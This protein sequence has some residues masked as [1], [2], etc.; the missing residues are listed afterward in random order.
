MRQFQVDGFAVVAGVCVSS[1]SSSWY[2]DA[3]GS[4]EAAGGIGIE[5]GFAFAVAG[6]KG[7]LFADINHEGAAR[8]ADRSKSLASNPRYK[9]LSA[10]L[11]VT[12]PNSVRAMADLAASEFGRIDYF[13]NAVGVGMK[14]FVPF[15]HTRDEDYDRLLAV[16]AKGAF[17]LSKAVIS[18]MQMQE[19]LLVDLGRHGVRDVGRGAIVNVCSAMSLGAVPAK[20]SYVASKHAMLGLTRA[21]GGQ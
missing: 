15:E 16:N 8:A 9:A 21:A 3:N 14:E 10:A 6:A 11:D 20:A 1:G 2:H 13:T 19:P 12:D 5:V 4:D 17:L 18:I 7:V